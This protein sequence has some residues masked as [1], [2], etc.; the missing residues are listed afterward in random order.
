[1]EHCRTLMMKPNWNN[2]FYII[3]FHKIYFKFMFRPVYIITQIHL[4]E[5][6]FMQRLLMEGFVKKAKKKIWSHPMNEDELKSR[7]THSGYNNILV[8]NQTFV[9]P[10]ICICIV[11]SANLGIRLATHTIKI[12]SRTLKKQV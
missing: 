1:M 9:Q 6:I 11:R 5:L 7:N 8:P 4:S 2:E 10:H 12:Y 3:L